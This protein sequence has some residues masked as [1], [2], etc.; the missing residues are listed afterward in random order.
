MCLRLP[1]TSISVL[2]EDYTTV[3]QIA[4]NIS[5]A[6]STPQ[7]EA[8]NGFKERETDD[9]NEISQMTPEGMHFKSAS[10]FL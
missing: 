2:N 6:E 8:M 7:E 1:L 3:Y 4:N 10:H 9:T 5:S